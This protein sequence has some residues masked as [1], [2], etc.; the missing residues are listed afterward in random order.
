VRIG[1]GLVQEKPL[2]HRPTQ[3]PL[4]SYLTILSNTL[5]VWP[6]LEAA[7]LE[8]IP[9]SKEASNRPQDREDA[10]VIREILKGR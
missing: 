3:P 10:A 6:R 1:A 5:H 9:R 4:I 2:Q 7:S 8:D